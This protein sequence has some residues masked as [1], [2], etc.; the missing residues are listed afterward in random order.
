MVNLIKIFKI[1][2]LILFL[3]LTGKVFGVE[4]DSALV[5]IDMQP[6]FK[7]SERVVA[8]V[9]EVRDDRY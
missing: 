2:G 3:K 7:R 1:I 8:A 6:G 9:C 5:I 4:F